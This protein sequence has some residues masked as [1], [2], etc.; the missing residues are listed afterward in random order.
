MT[1]AA[2]VA[3]ALA[4]ICLVGWLIVRLVRHES[5]PLVERIGLSYPLG[6]GALTLVLFTLSVSGVKLTRAS[7]VMALVLLCAILALGGRLVRRPQAAPSSGGERWRWYEYLIAATCLVGTASVFFDALFYPLYEWDAL[8]IWGLKAKII[9]HEPIRDS[10]YFRDVTKTYSHLGYPLLIPL[11]GA[12]VYAVLGRVDD[13][14]MKIIFPLFLVS[15]QLVLYARMRRHAGRTIALAL[16]ALLSCAPR[17]IHWVPK[18]IADPA[19]GLY[20]AIAA[21]YLYD[22]MTGGRPQDLAVAVLGAVFM[23]FTK[24]EGMALHMTVAPVV[25]AFAVVHRDRRGTIGAAVYVFAPLLLMPWLLS[26]RQISDTHENYLAQLTVSHVTDN[27]DRLPVIFEWLWRH[28]ISPVSW[29]PPMLLREAPD[30][31]SGLGNWNVAW[32]LFGLACVLNVRRLFTTPRLWLGLLWALH[33]ALYVLVYIITP[34]DVVRLLYV[35]LDRLLIHLLPFTLFIT[36]VHLGAVLQRDS[37]ASA[38]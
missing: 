6:I 1:D 10:A 36:A 7:G 27:L 25:I 21:I 37:S 14:L 33:L 24:N 26:F 16:V 3:A 15:M 13:R 20:Y 32:W 29:R 12:W 31:P 18:G 34:W 5:M 38:D 22:W 11:G 2:L 30:L 17:L 28:T 4:G 19:L 8:A 35:T 9:A 23:M